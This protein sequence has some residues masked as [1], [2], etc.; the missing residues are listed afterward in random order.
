MTTSSIH[1][2]RVDPF[3]CEKHNS[4]NTEKQPTYLLDKNLQKSND[5]VKL[6]DITVLHNEEKI[7]VVVARLLSFVTVAGKPWLILKVVIL[8]KICNQF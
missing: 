5:F 1:F 7:I 6:A 8:W 2:K 3:F 4:R